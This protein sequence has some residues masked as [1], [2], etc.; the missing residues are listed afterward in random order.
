MPHIQS[1]NRVVARSTRA[2][3]VSNLIDMNETKYLNLVRLLLARLERV[4]VDSFLAHRASGVRGALLKA[5][6]EI[7]DQNP[8]SIS[9]LDALIKSGFDILET[10][11]KEQ[12]SP[13]IYFHFNKK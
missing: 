3:G 11:F 7:E 13:Q 5:L 4:S 12:S 2:G 8:V 9:K 10:A 1:L 6:G